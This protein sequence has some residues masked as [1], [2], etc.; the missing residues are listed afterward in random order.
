M[1]RTVLVLVLVAGLAA[2][3]TAYAA[4]GAFVGVDLGVSVPTNDHYSALTDVGA[5]GSPFVGYM[6]NDYLGV[7]GQIQGAFHLPNNK[8]KDISK[9]TTSLLG[10]SLGPRLDLPLDEFLSLYVTGQG[11]YFTGLSGYLTHSAPGLSLG[12]GV[13]YYVT[14]QF[15]VGL[16]GRWNRAYMSARPST[17]AGRPASEQGPEDIQWMSAGVGMKYSFAQPEKPAPPPP[18]PPPPVAAPPPPPVKKKIVLRSV[19]FD[20]DKSGIRPDAV[21]VLD[22]AVQLLKEDPAVPVLV[23][24]HTDSVGSDA[25]NV[26]LSVRRADAVKEYLVSHGIAT[27]RL[28]AEGLGESQ[29]VAS[30]DTAEGRQQNRRVE[31]HVE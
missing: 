9:P 16:Q 13:D 4:E 30:N 23:Q 1:H 5:A 19:H 26:K 31:L 28:R 17:L 29:P 10:G 2:A 3:P 20:F 22:E 8:V 7:E 12:G 6:F 11:G 27:S 14:P 24:G 21:P 25:Y 18:P 15:S